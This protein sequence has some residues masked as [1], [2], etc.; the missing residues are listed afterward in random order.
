MSRTLSP[1]S[2]WLHS[3]HG[4]RSRGRMSLLLSLPHWPPCQVDPERLSQKGVLGTASTGLR[5]GGRGGRQGPGIWPPR[6]RFTAPPRAHWQ[7]A[8]K[9]MPENATKMADHTLHKSEPPL[10][11]RPV[12]AADTRP[13][14]TK[15]PVSSP[16][17]LPSALILSPAPM[18]STS[19]EGHRL[20]TGGAS[21]GLS[22][23]LGT[24]WH[25]TWHHAKPHPGNPFPS[26][27]ISVLL[28]ANDPCCFF[29]FLS[30]GLLPSPPPSQPPQTPP[31]PAL[32][33]SLPCL[34]EPRRGPISRHLVFGSDRVVSLHGSAKEHPRQ[35]SQP[36]AQ[37]GPWGALMG[38]A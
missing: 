27:F 4:E 1:P 28:L 30:S 7:L 2:S 37:R 31:R 22:V 8:H 33:P 21:W 9:H 13:R 5:L 14:P 36:R 6:G 24:V 35:A 18:P 12:P 17:G 3:S 16:T 25:G 20:L 19:A 29:P 11:P 10:P 38:R 23:G 26:S 15:G 34:R 32:Y